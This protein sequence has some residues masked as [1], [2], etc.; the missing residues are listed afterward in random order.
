MTSYAFFHTMK[1]YVEEQIKKVSSFAANFFPFSDI[2]IAFEQYSKAK[3]G[4]EL[5]PTITNGNH[6]TFNKAWIE[7]GDPNSDDIPFFLIHELRHV[8]QHDQI[9][10]LQS[11]AVNTETKSV[12]EKWKYEWEHYIYNLGDPVSRGKNIRQEIEIDANGYAMALLYLMHINEHDW[13][14]RIRMEEDQFDL[15]IERAQQYL[16]IKPELIAWIRSNQK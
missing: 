8:F 1:M 14:P 16:N 5:C 6:I 10:K 11:G 4:N 13:S 7:S 2:T 9:T 15:S 12:V 3:F